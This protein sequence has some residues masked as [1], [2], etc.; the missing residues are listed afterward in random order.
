MALIYEIIDTRGKIAPADYK[1]LINFSIRNL[2]TVAL[3]QNFLSNDNYIYS[4]PNNIKSKIIEKILDDSNLQDTL[5]KRKQFWINT[6]IDRFG[7]DC[8]MI[9][10]DVNNIETDSTENNI[11]ETI[12]KI[13]VNEIDNSNITNNIEVSLKENTSDNKNI[14]T[15]NENIYDVA[16]IS[17]NEETPAIEITE[18]NREEI[19]PEETNE[20]IPEINE[21]PE[22]NF[23]NT[24]FKYNDIIYNGLDDLMNNIDSDISREILIK[25]LTGKINKNYKRKYKEVLMKLFVFKDNEWVCAI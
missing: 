18:S 7:K 10:K 12:P 24:E 25:T 23:N 21:E 3:T 9:R 19:I 20:D 22:P 15:N 1:R 4:H 17:S 8:F 11:D 6:R 5:N 16:N 2:D 14:S 13:T